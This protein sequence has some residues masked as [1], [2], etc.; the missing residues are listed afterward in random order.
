MKNEKTVFQEKKFFVCKNVYGEN[1]HTELS[2]NMYVPS[3]CDNFFVHNAFNHAPIPE[4]TMTFTAV[5]V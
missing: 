2:S 1:R 4:Q 3:L 5:I